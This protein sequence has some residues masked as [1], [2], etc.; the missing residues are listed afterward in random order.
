MDEIDRRPAYC[1]FRLQDEGKP[2]PRSSCTECGRTIT[3][4]LGKSC[5]HI[6]PP[7]SKLA[8]LEGENKTLRDDARWEAQAKQAVSV[9][10]MIRAMIGEMFGSIANIESDEATLL[11]GPESKH[12]GEAILA[13]LQNIAAALSKPAALPAA[14]NGAAWSVSVTESDGR[15]Y[16]CLV[17]NDSMSAA[18]SCRTNTDNGETIVSQIAKQ[19]AAEYATPPAPQPIG[20]GWRSIDT[21]PEDQHVILGT[22]GGHVGEAIMLVDEDTGRQKWAWALGPLHPN[23][24]PYGWQPLP[25]SLSAP[26]RSD[27]RDGGFD[28][29]TGAE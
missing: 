5:Q 12:D 17:R 26:V 22:S 11:R 27:L 23:H 1:R 10:A 6:T 7:V 21:A 3:T 18:L 15:T 13:A 20:R 4:G 25:S 28:G 8:A 2:Y 29:P 19:F 16:L 9:I 24:I 14:G